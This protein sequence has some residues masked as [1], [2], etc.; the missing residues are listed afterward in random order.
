VFEIVAGWME[1][2]FGETRHAV[3]S[4]A[5]ERAV[6][7]EAGIREEALFFGDEPRMFGVVAEPAERAGKPLPALLWLN[8]GSDHRIGPNRQ[9]VTLSRQLAR[10]GF[11]SLRFDP[12]GVGD[13]PATDQDAQVHAY[14]AGRLEDA[15][16]A[17]NWL[18]Q[19]SGSH[20]FIL[21]GLCSGAFVAFHMAY[22]DARVIAAVMINPQTFFWKEG[23]SISNVFMPT[24]AYPRKLRN[25][26]TWMRALT[27]TIN[28]RDIA[29]VLSTRIAKRTVARI[30]R[31]LGLRSAGVFD[32]RGAFHRTLRRGGRIL[33]ILG[34]HDGGVE[35]T[36]LHLGTR[37][38]TLRRYRGFR[39]AIAPESDHTFSKR[40]AKDWLAKCLVGFVEK[41]L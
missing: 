7:E 17:M 30:R 9:Y 19:R 1:R 6:I 4:S 21:I 35:V 8:S 24:R 41:G 29:R 20:E 25:P 38:R 10:H 16:R 28:F 12:R 26:R 40:W 33:L 23:D 13:C 32:V 5:V 3:P 37:A 18:E 34:E 31:A 15:R 27:G 22:A 39:L 2:T 14:S 11:T 36:E